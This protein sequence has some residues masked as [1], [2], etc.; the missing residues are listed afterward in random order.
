MLK[1]SYDH[2]PNPRLHTNSYSIITFKNLYKLFIIY[3]ILYNPSANFTYFHALVR[4]FVQLYN[5]VMPRS[6]PHNFIVLYFRS[7]L[8]QGSTTSLMMATYV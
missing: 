7:F 6:C 1:P 2:P 5:E 8:M 3:T 4:T